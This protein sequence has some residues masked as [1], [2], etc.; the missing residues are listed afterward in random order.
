MNFWN[1]NSKRTC[2]I[3]CVLMFVVSEKKMK[4]EKSNINS[5]FTL[6]EVVA[7]LII[8][9]LLCSSVFV[10]IDRCMASTTNLE[11]RMQAFEVVRENME[12]LL[13]S[14]LVEET[15][16]FGSSEKYPEIQW[17]TTIEV[18]SEPITLKS[19]VQAICTAEYTDAAGEEQKVEMVHWLT[20]LTTE[21]LKQFKEGDGDQ[22]FET[23]EA[24]A[25]Y[26]DVDVETIEEWVTDG[27]TRTE[28]GYYI[29]GQLDLYK[30][31]DGRP[32]IEEIQEQ[33]EIDEKVREEKED[34]QDRQDDSD[35]DKKDDDDDREEKPDPDPLDD[36]GDMTQEEFD[37]FIRKMMEQLK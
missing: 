22:I 35:D 16:E 31:T 18:F 6:V 29:Q 27:M 20:N 24:A 2:H 33:A 21:Q 12:E 19:W 23:Q 5:G 1:L 3:K 34:E 17:E 32:T 14:K 25:E 13:T 37:E 30:R 36:D 26:A 9:A 28:E 11:L 8:L 10:V 7:S 4:R 15:V